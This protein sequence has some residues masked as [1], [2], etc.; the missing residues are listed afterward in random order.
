MTKPDRRRSDGGGDEKAADDACPAADDRNDQTRDAEE[1]NAI[2]ARTD[3]ASIGGQLGGTTGSGT[4]GAGIGMIGFTGA[5]PVTGQPV[6]SGELVKAT[7]AEV[8]EYLKQ[9]NELDVDESDKDKEGSTSAGPSET[10]PT[11]AGGR[12]VGAGSGGGA[13]LARDKNS[14]GRARHAAPVASTGPN[15]DNKSPGGR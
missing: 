7:Y 13:A 5:D 9:Y 11:T 12:S 10:D 4:D 6:R 15:Y 8:A 1:V 2:Q 3:R 14:E